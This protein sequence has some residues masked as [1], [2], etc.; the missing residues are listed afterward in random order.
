MISI[1]IIIYFIN[2]GVF[3]PLR[4]PFPGDFQVVRRKGIFYCPN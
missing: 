1:L 4:I 2:K 3:H